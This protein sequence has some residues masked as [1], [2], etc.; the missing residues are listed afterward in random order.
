MKLGLRE[1][2]FVCVMLGLLASSYFF[3]FD[4]MNRKRI[5][6][7]ADTA[8][9]QRCLANLRQ[10]TAGIDDLNRKIDEL[11]KAIG[12]FE[13]KLPQQREMDNILRELS[14]LSDEHGLTTRTVKT[15]KS[16]RAANYSEQPIQL[17]LNGDFYTGFY[18]FLQSLERLPRLTRLTQM[19]L[20][21][22]SDRNGAMT[23]QL[24][25]SIF[26]EPDMD[27]KN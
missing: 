11:Q 13:K 24:T 26:F 19:Q 25:V 16:E 2:L 22:L 20:L 14:Q 15:L 18:P 12:F 10:S 8:E 27:E 21:K 7:A 5:A 6:V 3:V 4:K 1:L 17:T 9:K 23:A